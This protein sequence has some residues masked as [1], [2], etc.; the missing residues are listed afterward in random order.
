MKLFKTKNS[1]KGFT[2]IEL[3]I[4]IAVLGILAAVVLVAI[5]PLEQ[6]AR[7]R[8]A[9]RKTAVGQ[10]GHA[11]QAYYTAREGIG[12]V[13]TS[14][15]YQTDLFN[16][17]ELKTVA[18]N[19][20][21]SAIGA[22]SAGCAAGAA[23]QGT[24][25]YQV[26]ASGSNQEAIVYARLESKVENNKCPVGSAAWYVWTSNLGRAGGLC[27]GGAGPSATVASLDF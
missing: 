27:T 24:Y 5:D 8:D 25:C 3:L 13:S 16:A 23:T 12:Y 18:T 26:F 4:V 21:Y 20:N 2:L 22:A 10:I 19:P 15:N 14:G 6:L 17:G 7:G 9:G 1:S 11:L